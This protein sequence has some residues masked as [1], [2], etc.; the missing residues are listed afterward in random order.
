ME[1]TCRMFVWDEDLK[2][3]YR[4]QIGMEEATWEF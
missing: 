3:H 1:W 4:Q 2:D